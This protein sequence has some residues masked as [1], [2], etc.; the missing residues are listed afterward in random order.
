MILNGSR[1]MGQPVLTVTTDSTGDTAAAV[2]GPPPLALTSFVYYTV[3]QG[4]RFDTIAS[5]VYG[6][7]DYWW[8]IADANPQVWYPDMLVVGSIIKLPQA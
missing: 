8:K 3:V 5:R 1:Y 2:F 6:I 7:S 4:D